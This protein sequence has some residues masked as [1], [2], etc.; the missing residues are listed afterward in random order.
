IEI[1]DISNINILD[2]PI[3]DSQIV[4]AH[5]S[6]STP[7][8][9]ATINE[10]Q[11]THT[12]S[13]STNVAETHSSA[14][15][16]NQSL[17]NFSRKSNSISSFVA[18]FK[19]VTTKQINDYES[20]WQQNFHDHVVRNHKRFETIYNYIKNNPHSWETDSINSKVQ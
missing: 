3:V 5:S 19:S 20:I 13:M 15:L 17:S 14:P 9:S 1:Q 18:I 4:E 11:L 7:S 2:S 10:A 12:Q 6:A 16:Q 8:I